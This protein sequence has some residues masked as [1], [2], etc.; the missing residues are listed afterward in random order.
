LLLD[1]FKTT[2][3]PS[4]ADYQNSFWILIPAYLFIL[5]LEQLVIKSGQNKFS[6]F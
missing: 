4:V 3:L 1:F 5:F 2:E 6:F